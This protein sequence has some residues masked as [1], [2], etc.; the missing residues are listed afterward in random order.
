M[1]ELEKRYSREFLMMVGSML[2]EDP[3]RR[4]TFD[5]LFTHYSPYMKG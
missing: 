2:H 4:V 3:H 1:V 5:H